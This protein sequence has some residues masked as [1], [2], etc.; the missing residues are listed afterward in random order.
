MRSF[1]YFVQKIPAAIYG[2]A[3]SVIA[4]NIAIFLPGA[5]VTNKR[6]DVEEYHFVICFSTP[7]PAVIN[8]QE[9]QFR[10]GSLICLAP[11]DDILV[12]PS[13]RPMSAR[14]MTVC[15]LPEFMVDVYRELGGV[16]KLG[17]SA[18]DQRYSHLL[19]EALDALIHEVLYHGAASPL[20]LSSLEDRIAVQLIRDGQQAVHL[21]RGSQHSVGEIVD[22]ACKY[23]ET[24]YTSSITVK[25]VSDA[26]F[27][28][29]S[30]LQKIFPRLVGKTPHQYIMECRHSKAQDMLTRTSM[31]MEEVARQCGFV[32]SSHFSTTF[33]QVE[34]ISPLTYRKSQLK[35]ESEG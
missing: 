13:D 15:V 16:G 2:Q 23:I 27:V 5:Y 22:K 18:L 1:N 35:V 4:K 28:S 9:Y 21:V 30:Y 33:K 32:N 17:F 3:M 29:P 12:R 19:L 6:M 25:D 7:P 8:E 34:G 10:K 31:S 14:H 11:G 26:I 20:M 24:Y